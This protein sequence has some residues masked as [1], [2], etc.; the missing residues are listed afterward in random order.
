LKLPFALWTTRLV[1]DLIE[2]RFGKRLGLPTM[3]LYLQRWGLSPQKPLARAK[4]RSPAAIKAWLETGYPAIAKRAKAQKAVIF[5]G[6]ETGISNQ[7]Q[8]GRSWAQR[9]PVHR[10][11]ATSDQGCRAKGLPDRRQSESAPRQQGHG[12]GRQPCP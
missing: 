5:W 12:M 7:D 8:I 3:H 1:R 6:D 2:Q 4:E 9:R 11:S 10:L